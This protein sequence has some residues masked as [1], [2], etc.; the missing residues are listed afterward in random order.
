[1]EANLHPILAENITPQ[2]SE[3]IKK[4]LPKTKLLI[5]MRALDFDIYDI[6]YLN[7]QEWVAKKCQ[8]GSIIWWEMER[9]GSGFERLF[10]GAIKRACL[11]AEEWTIINT[12]KPFSL[13]H[14]NE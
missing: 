6:A 2:V 13:D 10:K 1:M 11:E 5:V 9:E 14:A 7:E 4:I 3:A 8:D 12:E